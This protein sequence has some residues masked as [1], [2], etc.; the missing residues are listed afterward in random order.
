MQASIQPDCVQISLS[1]AAAMEYTA[2][3][4]PLAGKESAASVGCVKAHL[5]GSGGIVLKGVP[6]SV[7]S[8]PF[9]RMS[10][11]DLAWT[12]ADRVSGT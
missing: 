7:V 8:A 5:Q 10:L 1:L 3:C 12:Y 11:S 6:S 2:S 4:E 9:P